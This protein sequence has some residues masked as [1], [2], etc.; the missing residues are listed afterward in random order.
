VTTYQIKWTLT[1]QEMW[2]NAGK[3]IRHTCKYYTTKGSSKWVEIV[4]TA[5]IENIQKEYDIT[6]AKYIAEYWDAD[7]TYAKFNV[8]VPTST[9]DKNPDNC[10]FVNDL[11][12]PFV[13]SEGKLDLPNVTY[14]F[15]FCKDM[16]DVKSVGNI[17]VTFQF[18]EDGKGDGTTL[19]AKKT[20][21]KDAAF[22]LIATI[23]NS[24]AEVPYNTVTLNKESDL[25]KELL[26]TSAFK[27]KYAV[28]AYACDKDK[29]VKVTF[30]GNDCFEALFVRPVDIASNS[31]K[32]FTDGVD[33]GETGSYIDVKDL[34][35]PSDWRGRLF[36]KYTNYWG[37]YGAFKVVIDTE[38]VEC[39]LNSERQKV[40][41]TIE[42]S[43][44]DNTVKM[45]GKTADYGYLTYKNNG[46]STQADFNLYVRA[47]VTYGWGVIT[48][49]WITV[50]VKKTIAKQ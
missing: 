48:T 43:Q 34:I 38:T 49:D 22:E 28:N 18:G 30:N 36:S 20:D 1:P 11:N 24:G 37:F 45:G 50:K 21:E 29:V 9:S 44:T 41:A 3:T 10:V 42:L 19:Y 25:A 31:A 7:K 27:A 33:Y 46:T 5:T 2:D 6:K 26:N 47:T 12:S 32:D 17:N 35:N 16:L 23:D 8:A 13:T 40:P 4:L 14:S 39:N 15:A